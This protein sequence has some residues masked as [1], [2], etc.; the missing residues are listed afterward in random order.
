LLAIQ[1][2]ECLTNV[3]PTMKPSY[4]FFARADRKNKRNEMPVYLRITYNR[5]LRYVNTG[6]KIEEK[7]WNDSKEEVR[8]SHPAEKSYNEELRKLRLKAQQIGF[9]LGRKKRV[10]A[11]HIADQLKG[12]NPTDFVKFTRRYIQEL[13]ESGSIRLSKQTKVILNKII[14][15]NNSE[16]MEFS[17]IT[18]DFLDELQHFM[19]R[20]YK[21]HQNT[22]RK[23]YERLKMV[24]TEAEKKEIL[25]E[26]PFDK[27]ELPQRQKSN[28]EALTFEQIK[29]ME[30]LDLEK[31]S[32][33]YHVRNYFMF[34]FYN[35][36]IR[37]GDLC[38]LQWKNIQD[39]RLKY[40]MGKSLNTQTPKWK[41]IKL[42]DNCFEILKDYRTSGSEEDFI[43][44]ILDTSK[45]LEDPTVFDSDKGSKNAIINANL[46]ELAKLAGIELTLTFH[47]SRHSFARH[48]A[49][50]GMNVYAISNA[51][52][53][54][55]LK[56]T[57]T[58][59][60]SFN[61]SLLDR[62]MDS[63]F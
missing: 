46:K 43:F 51:L 54:S 26:N 52:A 15:F 1:N 40:V 10:S 9:E 22:I 49:N 53:H 6:I 20:E 55:N 32:D 39:G 21:N 56:T 48:A 58:Y 36:G 50:M 63:I 35:A 30:R 45:N 57:Q 24:F 13:K 37:F 31:G 61:E 41:N 18:H 59:L 3:L 7:H 42:T 47:I 33:L 19:K 62:E 11:K 44:P 34:S 12:K 14:K 5:K 17:E 29:T 2:R 60:S 23:D 4:T 28:K 8:K 16:T 38:K 25:N 27:Y